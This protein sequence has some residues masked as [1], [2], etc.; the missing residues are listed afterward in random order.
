MANFSHR[1]SS[2]VAQSGGSVKPFPREGAFCALDKKA[3]V[4]FQ[5]PQQ[6]P[7]GES[8]I[9]TLDYSSAEVHFMDAKGET[10]E[11]VRNVPVGALRLARLAEIPKGRR[12]NDATARKFGYV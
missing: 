9:V 4:L 7:T 12:P 11:V 3:G 8:G 6:N 10:N 2:A 1:A 5:Y